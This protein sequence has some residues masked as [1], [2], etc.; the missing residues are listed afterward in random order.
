MV[1][2]DLNI[3]C[4][5]LGLHAAAEKPQVRPVECY[6]PLIG[7]RHVN[8]QNGLT[9]ETVDI[10]VTPQRDHVAWRRR[11]MNGV[12][13]DASQGPLYVDTTRQYTQ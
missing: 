3:Q 10:K 8:P 9:Y 5:S 6:Q 2:Q 13:E 11:V 1:Y 4:H 7:T 12:V